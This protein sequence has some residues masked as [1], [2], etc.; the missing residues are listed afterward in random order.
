[1]ESRQKI[2]TSEEVCDEIQAA[3]DRGDKCNLGET[4]SERLVRKKE[5]EDNNR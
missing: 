1:L 5:L 4:N 2:R 3:V